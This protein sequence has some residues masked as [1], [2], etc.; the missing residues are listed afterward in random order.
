MTLSETR[1]YGR[2]LLRCV[3]YADCVYVECR[4]L[5]LYAECHNLA[6]YAQ[7]RKLALYDQCH[8][9]K[10]HYAYCRGANSGFYLQTLALSV[11]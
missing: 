11:N 7:C 3:I 10:C 5:A 4:N 1:H 8:Y 9:D 6:L 2:V